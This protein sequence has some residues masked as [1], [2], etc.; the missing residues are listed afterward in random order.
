VPKAEEAKQQPGGW[1][2]PPP[3]PSQS[4]GNWSDQPQS[5]QQP[6][7]QSG[8]DDYQPDQQG[9][10]V[11]YTADTSDNQNHQQQPAEGQQQSTGWEGQGTFTPREKKPK[12][13]LP[14]KPSIATINQVLLR[15]AGGLPKNRK[16]VLRAAILDANAVQETDDTEDKPPFVFNNT[17]QPMTLDERRAHAQALAT[18]VLPPDSR[19]LAYEN[20]LGGQF[21]DAPHLVPIRTEPLPVI[22]FDSNL[23]WSRLKYT[24]KAVKAVDEVRAE[25]GIYRK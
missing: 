6:Q 14:D 21:T 9:A 15:A 8:P 17:L 2:Q 12:A 5:Q 3:Q 18:G 4:S 25:C 23:T 1:D 24:E 19:G 11:E 10:Y 22:Q 7:Q 13:V 16:S 20:Q